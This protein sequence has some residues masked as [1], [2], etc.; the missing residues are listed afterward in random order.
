MK[1]RSCPFCGGEAKV[2]KGALRYWVHCYGCG[3]E[4]AAH[5]LTEADAACDWN[6]RDGESNE[7]E[8]IG[9]DGSYVCSKCGGDP[10]E[11]IDTMGAVSD[12]YMEIPMYFCP[13]CG[14]DM[15]RKENR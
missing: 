13:H 6:R 5:Y 3:V 10:M 15:R 7:G 1:I 11:F 14:A 12:A 2:V 4:L 8:W 9:H